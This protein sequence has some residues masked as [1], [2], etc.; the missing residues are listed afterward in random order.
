MPRYLRDWKFWLING[1]GLLLLIMVIVN[2][3]IASG[4][5]ARSKEV[6]ARQQYINQSIQLSRFNT[7]FIQLLANLAAQTND[8][9]LKQLLNQHGISYTINQPTAADAE[10][11]SRSKTGTRSK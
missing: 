1:L 8:D 7:Q 5:Q 4:N 10:K 9:S 11:D 2:I 3:R 6:V